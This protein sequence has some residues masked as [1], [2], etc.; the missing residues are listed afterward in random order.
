ML[1]DRYV[2][3]SIKGGT[4]DKRKEKKSTGIRRN[5]D[6]RDQ[7]IGNCERFIILEDNKASLAHFLST[8]ISESYSAPPGRELVINGGFKDTLKVWS[9]DTSRQDVREL[10][11][12]HEEADTRIVL[13]ARDAAARGYKQVNIL[14]RDTGVLVL[15]L[16]HREQLCQEIWMF[17]GTSRQR[18]Y[19]PVHRIRSP[20]RRGSRFWHFMPLLAVIR[21][22]S[23]M[24]WARHRHGKSSKMHLTSW[25]TLEKKAKTVL[26][27]LP[28]LKP[29]YANST[30]REHKR[31]KSTRKER[32]RFANPRKILTPYL[33]LK[34]N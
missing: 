2:K 7:R 10:A 34:I 18:R 24:V 3:N 11:S 33:R 15:L 19:I 17:A 6:N 9:S 27:F 31:W 30:I 14:C 5:V 16:A 8:E 32:Q 29:L 21:Q 20:R 22:A 25:N 12:D 26:T 1:F 4:R 28:K 23:S 13:H